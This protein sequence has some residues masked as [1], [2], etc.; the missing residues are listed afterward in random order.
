MDMANK[1]AAAPVAEQ[2]SSKR[3]PLFGF[4]QFA[5]KRPLGFKD[6]IDSRATF[7]LVFPAKEASSKS[8]AWLPTPRHA[9]GFLHF[10]TRV[11]EKSILSRALARCSC[12]AVWVVGCACA[13]IPINA[14]S[15]AKPKSNSEPLPLVL[16]SHGLSGSRH[17]YMLLAGRLAAKGNAVVVMEHRDGSASTWDDP[18]SRKL[19][20]YEFS[21]GTRSWRYSQLQQRHDECNAALKILG[22]MNRGVC[23]THDA[24]RHFEN[25]VNCENFLVAG[26]SFG[27]LTA[28]KLAIERGCPIA[29][30][31][32][33]MVGL[34]QGDDQDSRADADWQRAKSLENP[35]VFVVSDEWDVTLPKT[36]ERNNDYI[37]AMVQGCQNSA[38]VRVDG[39]KHVWASDLP[40]VTRMLDR[41]NNNI[42]EAN[43]AHGATV[44]AILS[45]SSSHGGHES[46][47]GVNVKH[48]VRERIDTIIT[49]QPEYSDFMTT[50]D[51]C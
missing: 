31:D 37:N 14:S 5:F 11:E 44:E 32:P 47:D 29:G 15:S 22:E 26:H 18:Q 20:L 16:L 17:S 38:L 36:N 1:P 51:S 40:A 27:S 19:R 12:F 39:V 42:T 23:E 41:K 3:T 24:A 21:D 48:S 45:A 2:A 33:W 34:S 8:V 9:L 25:F 10:Q 43:L 35:A 28:L 6:V 4:P 30:L 49:Q 7:R 13:R 46:H 50:I